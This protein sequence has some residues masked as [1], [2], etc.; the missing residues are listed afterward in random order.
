[1][2]T[3]EN[4]DGYR[5]EDIDGYRPEDIDGYRPED[6]P[7]WLRCRVL[8]FLDTAYFDN[9]VTAKQDLDAPVQ[10][11]ARRGSEVIGLLDA[12]LDGS[13]AT[14]ETLAVH[15]D[16]QGRGIAGDLLG[17]ALARLAPLGAR[18]LV[19]WTR[20]DAAALAWYAARGFRESTRYLHVYAS[21]YTGD[22]DDG[23]LGAVRAGAGLRA[24][25]LFAHAP[26]EREAELRARFRR[27][28]VCRRLDLD[29]S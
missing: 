18:T 20:E 6:E 28:H 17:E 1:M 2:T 7:S 29:L 5:P 23:L 26:I 21:A 22:L 4:I 19:A 9:V 11:V 12:S 13:T 27:V 24:M 8:S 16:H 14:L 15:P 25:G 10:L 3:T